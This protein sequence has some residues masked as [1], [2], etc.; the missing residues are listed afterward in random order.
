MPPSRSAKVTKAKV[1]TTINQDPASPAGTASGNQDG[2]TPQY[3]A[4]KGGILIA[5]A[6]KHA[7]SQSRR[8]T[9][10]TISTRRMAGR[11]ATGV[12]RLQPSE[13]ILDWSALPIDTRAVAITARS[14]HAD[15]LR[16]LG[17]TK[18]LVEEDGRWTLTRAS[19]GIRGVIPAGTHGMI[20]VKIGQLQ[21]MDRSILLLGLTN[22]PGLTRERLLYLDRH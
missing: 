3:A 2:G 17:E 22:Y 1:V 6:S 11:I 20:G 21:E 7:E 10:G 5:P 14:E 16:Y 19:S 4:T 8:F 18:V 13:F 9:P 15:L 12:A